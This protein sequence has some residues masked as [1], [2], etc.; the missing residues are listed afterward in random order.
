MDRWGTSGY[1]RTPTMF[2]SYAKS[3]NSVRD[4]KGLFASGFAAM[5]VYGAAALLVVF[6]ASRVT[7]VMAPPVDV[8]F[9]PPPMAAPEAPEK[10]AAPAPPKPSRPKRAAAAPTPETP[11]PEPVPPTPTAEPQTPIAMPTAPAAEA[12]PSTVAP[13]SG[14]EAVGLVDPNST[15]SSGSGA[16]GGTGTGA[17]NLPAGGI[18]P[19]PSR[20]NRIPEIPRAARSDGIE[21]LVVLRIVVNKEGRVS[22]VSV[23]EGHPML[24]AAA[25][26]AV[27][28][29]KYEPAR[30]N[31]KAVAVFRTLKIPFRLTN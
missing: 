3:Q 29:W 20:S 5:G 1:P 7:E 22:Q 16:P 15:G 17:I 10:P 24:A 23:L 11:P 9:A 26:E 13:S 2:E 8:L 18:A 28:T 27:K 25:V 4:R 12:D 6:F 30:V 14:S 31:G 19:K 21:G